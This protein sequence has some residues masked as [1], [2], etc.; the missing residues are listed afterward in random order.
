[1]II[2]ISLLGIVLLILAWLLLMPFTLCLDSNQQSGLLC[3]KLNGVMRYKVYI[4]NDKIM[5]HTHILFFKS[6]KEL[7]QKGKKYAGKKKIK[8][9]KRPAHSNCLK[10]W[11]GP[12]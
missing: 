5:S 4:E 10:S 7:F 11:F 9:N 8:K 2:L 6:E 1:M 12:F 3:I